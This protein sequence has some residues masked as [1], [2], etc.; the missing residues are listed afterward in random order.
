MRIVAP[1]P[2]KLLL[3]QNSTKTNFFCAAILHPI[4]AKVSQ[5]ETTS[6]QYYTQGFWISKKF[7]N[8]TSGSGCK[9]CLNRVN[10]KKSI[11][12]KICPRDFTP[13]YEL[14]FSNLRPLLSITFP[15]GFRI[16]KKFGHWTLENG[17]KMTFKRNEK[18]WRTNTHKY[19]HFDL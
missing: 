8:W 2:K 7:G 15:Q 3:R 19:G 1:I 14:K 5:S 10:K 16:S 18:M 6:F 17:G 12:K 9:K 4:W 11:T 13:L